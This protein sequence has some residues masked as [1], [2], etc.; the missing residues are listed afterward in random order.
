MAIRAIIFD[1]GGVLLEIDWQRYQEDQQSEWMSEDLRPYEGL[2]ARML[3]LLK[4]LRPTYTLATICNGGSR[5]AMMRKFRL[6]ELVDLM[7]FDEE[8]G[9]SKPDK[10]LYLLTL[11][12]LGIRPEEAVFV[13][14]KDENV[15]AARR[16]G[17]P[18]IHFKNARQAIQELDALLNTGKNAL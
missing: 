1:L 12:R 10:R 18:G 11:E 7:V 6:H 15:E 8:E 17:I 16:L 5:Q 3:Q 4:R 2:N 9:I 14:D 13:D